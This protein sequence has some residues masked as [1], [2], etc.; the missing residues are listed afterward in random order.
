MGLG[1]LNMYGTDF[2]VW[3]VSDWIFIL[4]DYTF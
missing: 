3:L 1:V 4:L 2:F